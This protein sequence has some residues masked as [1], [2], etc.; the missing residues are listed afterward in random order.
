MT[1]V[2]V[3]SSI[4]QRVFVCHIVILWFLRRNLGTALAADTA[5]SPGRLYFCFGLLKQHLTGDHAR[6]SAAPG[7]HIQESPCTQQG[8]QG[9][10]IRSTGEI[11]LLS[12]CAAGIRE[13]GISNHANS[14]WP[15]SIWKCC[16]QRL[17]MPCCEHLALGSG[18]AAG[19][20]QKEQWMLWCH[21]QPCS[22]PALLSPCQSWLCSCRGR[23]WIW[24]L[25]VT[26]GSLCSPAKGHPASSS[27]LPQCLCTLDD[28]FQLLPWSPQLYKEQRP[29]EQSLRHWQNTSFVLPGA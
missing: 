8:N 4:S 1:K 14:S 27:L 25:A 11:L 6:G 29:G 16:C 23:E 10:T 19:L 15:N 22:C 9:W 17:D 7:W 12:S 28:E 24:S 18:N 2:T 26:T 13:E 21:T 20:G 5:G 3:K